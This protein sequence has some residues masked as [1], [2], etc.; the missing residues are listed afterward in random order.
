[1]SEVQW[2]WLE[3]MV[4][5]LAERV[6]RF[7]DFPKEAEVLFEFSPV[8]MED[9]VKKELKTECAPKVIRLFA[10]KI[11]K[12]EEFDYDKF[13]AMAREIQDETGCK[14]KDLYHPLRI[15]LTA[16]GSGLDLDKFIPLVEEGAKQNFPMR[17]KNCSQRVSEA[18]KKL[19]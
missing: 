8:E 14:G 10:E 17:V 12:V 7:S 1:M 16:K 18:I 6:D 4:D 19:E 13:T 9:E 15:V 11:S 2:E 3:K 5:G